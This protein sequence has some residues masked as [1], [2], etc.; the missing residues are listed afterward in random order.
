MI[1]KVYIYF[2]NGDQVLTSFKNYLKMMEYLKLY[3]LN[4]EVK[5]IIIKIN[6]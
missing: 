3:L 2:L 1:Y 5:K 6:K 4:N